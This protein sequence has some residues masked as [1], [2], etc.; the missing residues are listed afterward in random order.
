MAHLGFWAA[1]EEIFPNTRQQRCWM[2]ETGNVLNYLPKRTQPKAKKMLHDIWHAE[3]RDDAH[4]AFDLFIYTFEA[5][6]PKATECL[7]KDREELMTFYDFRLSSGRVSEPQTRSEA[8]SPRSGTEPN[9]QGLSKQRR[10]A[11]HDVQARATCCEKLAQATRVRSPRRHPPRRQLHQRH[12]AIKP[13]SS[14]RTKITR[15]PDLT[16]APCVER[17]SEM[18][19]MVLVIAVSAWFVVGVAKLQPTMYL[20]GHPPIHRQGAEITPRPRTLTPRGSVS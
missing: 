20:N 14:R 8:P 7:I 3:T 15:T 18:S 17:S 16:I 11:A 19:M 1:L 2:H 9:K 5:K 12:Q 4:S 10:H 13:R 6:Y